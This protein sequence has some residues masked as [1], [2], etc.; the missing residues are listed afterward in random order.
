M[1]ELDRKLMI[2]GFKSYGKVRELMS[3]VREC[4][5]VMD[6]TGEPRYMIGGGMTF[7]NLAEAEMDLFDLDNIP[8]SLGYGLYERPPGAPKLRSVNPAIKALVFNHMWLGVPHMELPTHIP[9]IVVGRD[10][11]E[12]LSSDP[13]NHNFMR[14][15]VTAENLETAMAFAGKIAKTDKVMVFDGAFG[16]LTCS[17][18]LAEYL[19][20]RAP[21]VSKR[22]DE[23]LMP[24][25][26][27]QR[28]IDPEQATR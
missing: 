22:V 24:K 9:T 18:S 28:G 21:A 5:A 17:R 3:E 13:M 26:L 10:L 15:V 19:K 7:G 8:V 23:Q 14:Y 16:A 11:A 25:W 4:I 6:A 20:E 2:I 1:D 27:R 12:I